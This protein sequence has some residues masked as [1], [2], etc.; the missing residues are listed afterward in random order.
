M[1]FNARSSM[2]S[3]SSGGL[4]FTCECT[5]L[6]LKWAVRGINGMIQFGIYHLPEIFGRANPVAAEII[7]LAAD[8]V[9]V[10]VGEFFAWK[11]GRPIGDN[12]PAEPPITFDRGEIVETFDSGV[13]TDMETSPV[14]PAGPSDGKASERS[15]V[16]VID[17][18]PFDLPAPMGVPKSPH[19]PLI[20]GF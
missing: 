14:P 18:D 11:V 9:T 10:F 2:S 20:P 1:S 4:Q 5:P 15:P 16:H 7:E 17:M 6:Q 19:P 12:L 3:S 13:Q 8:L